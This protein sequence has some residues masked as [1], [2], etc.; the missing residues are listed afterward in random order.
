MRLIIR[1][2]ESMISDLNVANGIVLIGSHPSCDIYLPDGRLAPRHVII[3][4]EGDYGWTVRPLDARLVTTVNDSMLHSRCRLKTGDT[5]GFAD[6]S[7]RVYLDEPAG[8]VE[9]TFSSV[10]RSDDTMVPTR[11]PLPQDTVILRPSDTVSLEAGSLVVLGQVNRMLYDAGESGALLEGVAKF[12]LSTFK[13]D[14]VWACLATDPEHEPHATFAADASNRPYKGPD[15][16]G[17]LIHRCV[18]RQQTLLLPAD[19]THHASAAAAPLAAGS[20]SLGLV[21][22][23]RA[24]GKPFFTKGDLAALRA[25]GSSAGIRLDELLHGQQQAL[26]QQAQQLVEWAHQVQ[27]RLTP[28]TLP[29]WDNME[30]AAYRQAGQSCCGDIYDVVRLPKGTAAFVLGH[31]MAPGP[32][33]AILMAEVRAAFRI[34]LLHADAPHFLLKELNWLV[35]NPEHEHQHPMRCA[36]GLLD[37]TSG[38]LR[39]STAGHPGMYLIRSDGEAEDLVRGK[40]PQ[41]GEQPQMEYDLEEAQIEPGESVLLFTRGLITASSAAGEPFGVERVLTNLEDVPNKSAH[42]ILQTVV[43]DLAAHSGSTPLGEDVTVL[44]LRRVP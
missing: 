15:K 32:E 39:Y 18:Q 3:E 40:A 33:S 25:I 12:V 27:E 9:R 11:W 37:P 4:P 10:N 44:I 16:A 17:L 35:H 6:Y 20:S 21:H 42:V 41:L 36:T 19:A 28:P 13:A 1:E 38:K 31:A 43:D 14:H 5:I 2:R 22:M 34:G 26:K 8:V 23:D 30:V 7:V 29:A 24:P